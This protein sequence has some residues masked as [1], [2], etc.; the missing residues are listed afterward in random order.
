[1]KRWIFF[2]FIAIIIISLSNSSGRAIRG[3]GS[4]GAPGD[5][6]RVC[7]SCHN[8][9]SIQV[10]VRTAVLNL[11]RDTVT[12]Y[13]P[14]SS[15]LLRVLIDTVV[16][17]P[18][19]YGMQAVSIT[20]QLFLNAGSW[21]SVSFPLNVIYNPNTDRDYVEHFMM[22]DTNQFEALWKAPDSIVGPITFY[23]AAVG[24]NGSGTSAGDG[25][26]TDQVTLLADFTS[27]VNYTRTESIQIYPNPTSDR[28]RISIDCDDVKIFTVHGQEVRSLGSGLEFEIAD[29]SPG[30]YWLQLFDRKSHQ[31]YLK[32]LMK[33]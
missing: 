6:R 3:Q 1:M 30:I 23:V 11:E 7:Q 28:F 15:Y 18:K 12:S 9:A 20:D 17:N 13:E 8:S 14:G 33:I 32:K 29:L 10:K 31:I 4:T 19:G 27:S 22:S 16:G 24:V 25:G 5:G 2:G 21:D 26:G